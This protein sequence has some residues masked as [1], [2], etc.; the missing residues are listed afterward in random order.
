MVATPRFT[1][2]ELLAFTGDTLPDLIP[3]PTRLL[4]AGIN[5]GLLSVAVRAH[6]APRGNRFFPAL[7]AAGILDRRIDASA[8]MRPDD[9]AHLRQ[10]GI[11]ITSMVRG[12][13]AKASD[14]S[15]AQLRA[16]AIDLTER[17]AS[18]RP[19]V[20]AFLGI[21]AYRVAFDSPHASTGRQPQDWDGTEVWVVPNPSGL[22]RHYSVADLAQAYREVAIRA[23]IVPFAEGGGTRPAPA[24]R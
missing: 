19:R 5:P 24:S 8:G 12:A 3:D 21:S 20:L 7:L 14:L 11:G 4:F 23:G 1:R 6:F 17:V 10:R 2:A 15:S 9:E 16:G 22:N 18:I 13:T